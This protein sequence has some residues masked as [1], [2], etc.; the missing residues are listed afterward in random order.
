LYLEIDCA[1]V[2]NLV[3]N[4]FPDL[5]N[6]EVVKIKKQGHDNR[7]FRLGNEL[8]VRL[9]SHSSYADAV[10]KEA[11]AL[12]ALDGTLSVDIPKVFAIGE[13]SKA[14]PLP[15]SIRHW[16]PGNT[17]EETQVVDRCSLADALGKV[18]VELRS[19]PAEISLS[20]GKH[21]FYRGC[22]P[23]AY[24][25]EVA[26]SLRRVDDPSK[27]KQCL[28]I[29]HRGMVT[30]WSDAPVWFHGDVAVGNVLMKGNAVSALID[31]GTCGVGDPACDL[32][33]AW[34]YFAS[35]ERQRFR[36]AVQVDDGTWCRA[37]AWALWK[38]LVS[39]T[40]L[41]G[42]DTDGVQAR[43]LNEILNDDT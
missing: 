1:L 6:L 27:T 22:H 30:V 25:D 15:W 32:T 18:L 17:W 41:S 14:Y 10:H 26:E 5:S 43:A 38:A 19:V 34:T 21:S 2:Q 16:L 29:W 28:E 23:S 39:I 24:S 7:T 35:S 3:G 33:V 11:I 20:A 31:F 9:P 13:P 40:G 36:D 37:K 42:Q 12:Q 4:Q 8:S